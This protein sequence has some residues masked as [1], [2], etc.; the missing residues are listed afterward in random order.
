MSH[1]VH[2]WDAKRLDALFTSLRRATRPGTRLHIIEALASGQTAV[3]ARVLDLM[4]LVG[5]GG[6]ERTEEE[7]RDLLAA[8]GFTQTRVLQTGTSACIIE[9]VR[10]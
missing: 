3:P 6:Q 5:T 9:A 7:Y 8:H 1:A 2:D 10:A 4:M